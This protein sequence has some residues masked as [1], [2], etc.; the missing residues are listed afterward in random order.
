MIFESGVNWPV[1]GLSENKTAPLERKGEVVSG[2][3]TKHSRQDYH[4]IICHLL[5]RYF[6][7]LQLSCCWQGRATDTPPPQHIP[8]VSYPFFYCPDRN[9]PIEKKIHGYLPLVLLR[10]PLCALSSINIA[11]IEFLIQG[12][13]SFPIVIYRICYWCQ[14]WW[15]IY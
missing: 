5:Y 14:I 4:R 3:I 8:K 13:L 10:C 6:L 9:R 2:R 15:N 12:L 7:L 11:V 1:K